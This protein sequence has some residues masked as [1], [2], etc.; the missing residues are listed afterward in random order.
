[1]RAWVG[2]CFAASVL[3]L[4]QR[5]LAKSPLL[6]VPP[7]AANAGTDVAVLAFRV[8]TKSVRLRVEGNGRAAVLRVLAADCPAASKAS[9]GSEDTGAERLVLV[10]NFSETGADL[11]LGASGLLEEDLVQQALGCG[12]VVGPRV[13]VEVRLHG[14]APEVAWRIRVQK[15]AS[16]SKCWKAASSSEDYVGWTTTAAPLAAEPSPSAEGFEV[17]V[18]ADSHLYVPFYHEALPASSIETYQRVSREVSEVFLSTAATV[19]KRCATSARKPA[20]VLQMGDPFDLHPLGEFMPPM[21]QQDIAEGSWG[22]MASMYSDLSSACG[23]VYNVL[24]NWEGETACAPEPARELARSIRTLHFPPAAGAN[25]NWYAVEHGS[26]L[27]VVLHVLHSSPKCHSMGIRAKML[28]DGVAEGGPEDFRLGQEQ[29]DF[30]EGTLQN[31]THAFKVVAVHHPLAGAAG[32]E[33]NTRYG[34]G[35]SKAAKLGEQK[36]IH[37]VMQRTGTQV[38]LHAHDHLFFDEVVDGVHYTCTGTPSAPWVFEKEGAYPRDRGGA[39]M[40]RY[41]YTRL[42]VSEGARRMDVNFVSQEGTVVGGYSV[43]P[44]ESA[45]LKAS[46]LR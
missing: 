30:L 9:S 23:P 42:E 5:G 18:L 12:F 40:A 45:R 37:E 24:G 31:S 44:A 32:D 38:M 11:P 20:Y 46:W 43:E 39:E 6:S 13:Y 4:P 27:L 15:K 8:D 7:V 34:R 14:V 28:P 2:A 19:E 22:Y 21:A 36:W 16:K 10:A 17:M 25:P 35:G 3:L 26:L 41:G 1:M 33:R 29:R